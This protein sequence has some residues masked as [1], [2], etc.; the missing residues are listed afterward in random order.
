M[1]LVLLVG[2]DSAKSEKDPRNFGPRKKGK[3]TGADPCLVCSTCNFCK[4]CAKNGGTCGVC[5]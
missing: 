3:C 2:C 1:M 4:R 5:S